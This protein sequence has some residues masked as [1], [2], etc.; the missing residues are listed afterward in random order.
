M[1]FYINR[2]QLKLSA[3]VLECLAKMNQLKVWL[4]LDVSLTTWPM[5]TRELPV[6]VLV[7]LPV[8]SLLTR[9]RLWSSCKGKER[10]LLWCVLKSSKA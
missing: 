3:V 6:C 2:L 4:T 8:W 7:C 10:S 5:R 9:V 1:F